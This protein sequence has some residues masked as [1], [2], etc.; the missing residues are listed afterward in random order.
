MW[1]HCANGHEW[2]VAKLPM[3]LDG[4]VRLAKGHKFCPYCRGKQVALCGRL[5]K[6]A[7]PAEPPK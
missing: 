5:P 4:F 6:D 2:L 7:V 3:P 1:A